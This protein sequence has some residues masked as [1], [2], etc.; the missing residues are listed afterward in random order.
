MDRHEFVGL[1][2]EEAALAHLKDLKI[3][4]RYGVRFLLPQPRQATAQ[5]VRLADAR[6]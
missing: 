2:A 1:S 5:R 3:Q 6:L 4:G